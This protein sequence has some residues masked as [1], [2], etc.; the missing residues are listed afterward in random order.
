MLIYG[1]D[2]IVSKWVAEKCPNVTDFGANTSIGWTDNAGNLKAGFVFSEYRPDCETVQLSMA[3]TSP[4]WARKETIKEVLRYPFE[5]LKVYKVFT[6]TLP[7]NLKALKV[8]SRIGF[9]REAVLAHHFGRKKHCV[10]MRLLLPDYA[11]LFGD[12]DV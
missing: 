3:A 12:K 9:K 8:N 5:Q 10:I 4:M 1:Q 11:R 2:E 7:D 6:S